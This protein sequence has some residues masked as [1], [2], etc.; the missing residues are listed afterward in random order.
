MELQNLIGNIIKNNKTELFADPIAFLDTVRKECRSEQDAIKYIQ[1]KVLLCLNGKFVQSLYLSVK[2][3]SYCNVIESLSAF[4]DAQNISPRVYAY[5]IY[6][7]LKGCGVAADRAEWFDPL[8][9]TLDERS[10]PKENKTFGVGAYAEDL[11]EFCAGERSDSLKKFTGRRALVTVPCGYRT[12]E[13]GA[14]AH[15]REIRW[16]TVPDTVVCIQEEAFGDCGELETVVLSSSLSEIPDKCFYDA[17][18]LALVIA[19][20]VRSVGQ[21][22][23][24]RSGI[25]NYKKIGGGP[26]K[27]GAFAF[28]GCKKLKNIDL[29]RCRSA[30]RGAFSE[31]TEIRTLK[32]NDGIRLEAG[33]LSLFSKDAASFR[34]CGYHLEE[35]TYVC[36]RGEIPA[37]LFAGLGCV[38]KITVEGKVKKIGERA[39][40]DCSA[41]SELCMDFVG[42]E[43]PHGAFLNCGSMVRFPD[44]PMV[45]KIGNSAFAGC[46][47]LKTL[48]FGT[49][50]RTVGEGAF[51]GCAQ[52]QNPGLS[53]E[54]GEIAAEC[55]SGCSSLK[56][57]SLE[58]VRIIGRGAF[59]GCA[60]GRGLSLSAATEFVGEGAFRNAEIGGVLEL[61]CRAAFGKLAFEGVRGVRDLVL[62][63]A[64]LRDREGRS[65]QIYELF[66]ENME[67]FN[68]RYEG[69]QNVKISADG[70]GDGAFMGW[71]NLKK[72]LV[73]API[74]RIGKNAFRN[75]TSLEGVKINADQV[76]IGE[77]AFAGCASLRRL[78]TSVKS[79]KERDL[80]LSGVQFIGRLAFEGC[81]FESIFIPASCKAEQEAFASCV[82]LK[83]IGIDC[84]TGEVPK[85]PY[86]Y[87]AKDKEEFNT[88]FEGCRKAVYYN[89]RSVPEGF[90]EGFRNLREIGFVG[91]VEQIG[92][93]AFSA[94]PS[95]EQV[96]GCYIGTSL[97]E[98]SFENCANLVGIF[99]A[100]KVKEIGPRA[101]K[102]CTSLTAL[103][104]GTV[105][106][107]GDSA[108]AECSSLSRIEGNFICRTVGAYAFSGCRKLEDFS[109][110]SDAREAGAYAFENS[111]IGAFPKTLGYIARG[112]FKNVSLGSVVTIPAGVRFEKGALEGIA[113]FKTLVLEEKCVTD[114]AGEDFPLYQLFDDSLA[115]FNEKYFQLVNV[116]IKKGLAAEQFRGWKKIRKVLI[117][118]GGGTEIPVSCFDGCESLE[119]VK[120]AGP[121]LGIERFAF[122]NCN[123]LKRLKTGG[124]EEDADVSLRQ[125]QKIAENAFE[126]CHSVRTISFTLKSVSDGA[127]RGCD[128][129]E[130]VKVWLDEPEKW[131]GRRICSVFAEEKDFGAAYPNLKN[132]EAE[133]VQILPSGLFS[134]CKNVRQIVCNGRTEQLGPAAFQGCSML[135]TLRLDFTGK[136]LPAHCFEDCGALSGAMRFE[137]VEKIGEAAFKNCGRITEIVFPSQVNVLGEECFMNCKNLHSLQM[138]FT[139]TELPANCFAQCRALSCPPELRNTEEIH[140]QAFAGC[141][142]IVHLC[143][144]AVKEG[145]LET[146]FQDSFQKIRSVEYVSPYIPDNFFKGMTALEKIVFRKRIVRIGNGAFYGTKSL[147]EVGNLEGAESV[148]RY[149]FAHSGIEKIR[150]TDALE[151]IGVGALAGC[152]CLQT[153]E[154]PACFDR[155]GSLFD[156]KQGP[157]TKEIVQKHSDREKKYYLPSS[158]R[159]VIIAGGQ[160]SEG[161]F[162]GV[163]C[164]VEVRFAPQEI[165][166]DAFYGFRGRLDID[167]SQVRTVGENAFGHVK[168][169]D[170][171]M[172][173]PA[174]VSIGRCAFEGA[175]MKALALGKEIRSIAED[176]FA[177]AEIEKLQ[178]SEN[179]FYTAENS[180]LVA[181]KSGKLLYAGKGI[182]GEVSLGGR[183]T[184]IQAHAFGDCKGLTCIR[185]GDA[186]QIGERAF[187]NCSGLLSLVISEK[188]QK[189]GRGVCEGCGNIVYLELPFLGES[190]DIPYALDYVFGETG[191]GKRADVAVRGGKIAQGVFRTNKKAEYGKIDLSH[192]D[193]EELCED[194]FRNADIGELIL[195]DSL[196]TVREGAF[197]ATVADRV[198]FAGT[199]PLGNI[200]VTEDCIYS[201]DTL[202][203]RFKNCDLLNIRGG[204]KRIGKDAFDVNARA[205]KLVIADAEML[206]GE[207]LAAVNT[208]EGVS[209]LEVWAEV[210]VPFRELFKTFCRGLTSVT[211]GGSDSCD[212]MFGGLESLTE[213]LSPNIRVLK[214]GSFGGCG[215]LTFLPSFRKL[216]VIEKGAFDG[217]PEISLLYIPET[218]QTIDPEVFDDVS[219]GHLVVG[220]NQNYRCEGGILTDRRRTVLYAEKEIK[221]NVCLDGA[222][223][224]RKS[225]FKNCRSLTGVKA[226]VLLA[227]GDNAFEGCKKL[228]SFEVM[229]CKKIGREVLHGCRALSALR[230]P[231][232]GPSEDVGRNILYL[233]SPDEAVKAGQMPAESDIAKYLPPALRK[234]TLYRQK[235]IDGTFSGCAK[236]SEIKLSERTQEISSMSFSKCIG[237]KYLVIPDSVQKIGDFAFAGCDY[238]LVTELADK[239]QEAMFSKK[240]DVIKNG[241][242]GLG[243]KRVKVKYRR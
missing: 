84:S 229:D 41:L 154:M 13:K 129:A 243:T 143:I 15:H 71:K 192:T 79:E 164:D 133:N 218:I 131:M 181:E 152:N 59:A 91:N 150:F 220:D 123:M 118:S 43:I 237:L 12:I 36:E 69:M 120:V 75:C 227:I 215:K 197:G 222:S 87:F 95:L 51:S 210:S 113:D 240:W 234:V 191:A 89:F 160:L 86:F 177:R 180:L 151:Q 233:F 145:R 114:R 3:G 62:H 219:V 207:N 223:E 236:L 212:G 110:L 40:A 37:A 31:C 230:L 53:F 134:G 196:K 16:L 78:K 20:N 6:V 239:K 149:A 161:A 232:I 23:F 58:K 61:P 137:N 109:F 25:S 157:G 65:L 64:S 228:S 105:G 106:E 156:W 1:L 4:Y 77:S 63:S 178:I 92:R 102:G 117:E 139:G 201:A 35:I 224:I 56:E 170:Q 44:F 204:T 48:C 182:S 146:L 193:C 136:E 73:A 200:A 101:F 18:K 126:N 122:R 147:K 98:S 144:G 211:Y 186:V 115:A 231:Y 9:D 184:E 125:T 213:L 132:V 50:V 174:V 140:A 203:Y 169:G 130:T 38:R 159:K 27:I 165:P 11:S 202:V 54:S 103:S 111:S 66:A 52:L 22:A 121:L 209:V 119:G 85:P 158:L 30:E 153:A 238:G 124:A 33:L 10:V 46:S 7:V 96:S 2:D 176:A 187:E 166:N 34:S 214:N 32:L 225:A 188:T 216:E 189:M 142:A 90:F 199:D 208:L 94:L 148:G 97:P 70:I 183:V 167:V 55:F 195:P 235:V 19:P 39:F 47:S 26:E 82:Q 21:K 8:Q 241:F 173:L 14:F 217:M 116:K 108:F 29:S 135:E 163:G 42:Q 172:E 67:T 74:D 242:L 49:T 5:F 194:S 141:D 128:G 24:Y 221:G 168:F 175:Q 155:F 17:G 179:E 190:A 80:D 93:A 185:V 83:E 104:F 68:S 99:A 72:V 206:S 138:E 88:R 112:A 76:Q 205:G 198:L 226:D 107:L 57:I 100:E 28:F 60:F 45:G 162:S 81:P 127:F 171:S